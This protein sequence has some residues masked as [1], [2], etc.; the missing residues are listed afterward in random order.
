MRL[1][2]HQQGGGVRAEQRRHVQNSAS[3]PVAQIVR[4]GVNRTDGQKGVAVHLRDSHELA[5]RGVHSPYGRF[6]PA[7]VAE[8]VNR[9][10]FL[11]ID[12]AIVRPVQIVGAAKPE[13]RAEL[14]PPVARVIA[15]IDDC[16]LGAQV[17]EVH[18]HD[19][20]RS[21]KVVRVAAVSGGVEYELRSV[22]RVYVQVFGTGELERSGVVNQRVLHFL[23]CVAGGVPAFLPRH[24]LIQNAD[25]HELARARFAGHVEV[26]RGKLPAVLYPH[27]EF[28]GR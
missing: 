10:V 8:S 12:V 20:H 22:K 21:P 26:V 7:R 3:F 11:L 4:V 16:Y 13:V 6:L 18:V 25:L 14:E 24:A 5:A 17:R 1:H 9:A 28:A 27:V 15:G 23:G 19:V 2:V